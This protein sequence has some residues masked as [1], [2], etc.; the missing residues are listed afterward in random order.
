M[1]ISDIVICQEP[2]FVEPEQKMTKIGQAYSQ[3]R[4]DFEKVQLELKRPKI[5]I[6][7]GNGKLIKQAVFIEH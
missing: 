6:I 5:F 4:K 3:A 7:D 1:L 2:E